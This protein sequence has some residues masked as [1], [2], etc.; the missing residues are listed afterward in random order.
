MVSKENVRKTFLMDQDYDA[1][2][3]TLFWYIAD[4]YDY[5]KSIR[6]NKDVI[7]DM[8]Q[9]NVP[10]ALEI[11]HASKVFNVNKF[12]LTQPV[13]IDMQIKVE[14]DV[15]TLEATFLVQIRQKAELKPVRAHAANRLNLPV[16]DLH[17]A[18]A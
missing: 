15:I 18:T 5:K 8:D 12:S 1:Q 4:D 16:Q 11:L 17:F 7:L 2:N 9:K 3:D 10:V 13:G 14:K 6:M